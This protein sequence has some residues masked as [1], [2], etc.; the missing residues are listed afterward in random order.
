MVVFIF[1][2][3]RF[4]ITAMKS[5]ISVS[6]R[7]VMIFISLAAVIYFILLSGP[8]KLVF[9]N[10][11]QISQHHTFGS[12]RRQADTDANR[13]NVWPCECQDKPGKGNQRWIF[14]MTPTYRRGTQRL[15]LVRLFNTLGH[16]QNL[17]LIVVEDAKEK[18]KKVSDLFGMGLIHHWNHSNKL[19]TPGL[20]AQLLI[21]V[22]STAALTHRICA[23]PRSRAA[24]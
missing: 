13:S 19:S 2:K 24:K 1:S 5:T 6:S 17:Y 12:S 9:T 3:E 18:S 11:E 22:F 15:D 10:E 7:C 23:G 16:I 4:D 14:V 21:H 20:K 8:M